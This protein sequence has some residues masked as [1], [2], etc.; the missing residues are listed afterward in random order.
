MERLSRMEVWQRFLGDKWLRFSFLLFLMVSM[1]W[2][3]SSSQFANQLNSANFDQVVQSNE[4][5][6]VNFYA[7]WC[8]F[9]QMLKP[10]WEEAAKATKSEFPEEGRVALAGVDCESE[11]E[12]A[13]KYHISKY[14]TLKLF[15]NGRLAKR[16][17]RSQRSKDAFVSFIQ[18][19]MKDPIVMLQDKM[20]LNNID[21]KKRNVIAYFANTEG[22]DYKVFMRVAS[23][24]RDD[25]NFYVGTGDAFR[26]ET[27]PG[28]NIMFRPPRTRGDQDMLYMGTLN[29]FEL[30]LA[31]AN[32][33]C[34]PLVREITFEN[35]EELTEEGLPFLIL[36]HKTEDTDVVQKYNQVISR[37]LIQEKG[38]INFLTADGTKFTHPLHHLGKSAADLPLVA[39]DSFRHMYLFPDINEL[40]VPM[41]LKTFVQD[42]HSGK[43]HREFHHG[44]DPVT[45]E[46]QTQPSQKPQPGIE[47]KPTDP[48]ESTF[49][50]LKPSEHRYSFGRDGRDEL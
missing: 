28:N 8:R 7:N 26:P 17:Y 33:K 44:P 50:K 18:E 38:N 37:E 32:D 36:F 12:I 35:G 25:C 9:S 10:I 34:I 22:P 15:R 31:W 23:S 39:I 11:S 21:E 4:V 20:A 29:N 2:C 19:Q 3:P 41:K 24:L 1:L 43:L 5:V 45:P 48:P 46:S 49:V 14:P 16:E 27:V 6:F 47:K 30:L 13:K 42:L 40:T